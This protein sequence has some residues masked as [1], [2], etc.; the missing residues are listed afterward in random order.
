MLYI[1]RI[2]C[3]S[4]GIFSAIPYAIGGGGL[5]GG[6]TEWTQVANNTELIAQV[7]QQ[8]RTYDQLARQFQLMLENDA[9]LQDSFTSGRF[10][11]LLVRL[12]RSLRN[13]AIIAYTA[14]NVQEDYRRKFPTYTDYARDYHGLSDAGH[15]EFEHW[16]RLNRRNTEQALGVL[17]INAN[18][19][20]T[21]GQ[22][23]EKLRR[24]AR[25]TRSRK[26]IAQIGNNLSLVQLEQSR[27]MENLIQTQIAMQAN[28]EAI[29][30]N[31][32]AREEARKTSVE[33]HTDVWMDAVREARRERLETTRPL[34][35]GTN[36]PRLNQD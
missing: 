21:E 11:D 19:V 1:F 9:S 24:Q 25:T 14:E 7:R 23:I 31:R 36:I 2:F 4:I 17:N 20:L 22:A 15:A 32:K 3:L 5:T 30:T 29:E 12:H 13:D 26:A 16:E 8:I 10:N 33:D 18:E 28:Y 35:A 6:A 27:R 34:D